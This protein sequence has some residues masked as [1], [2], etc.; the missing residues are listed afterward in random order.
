MHRWVFDLMAARLAGRP[1]YFPAQ[2]D[3]L[4]RCADTIPLERL[5]RF[6]RTL[7]ERRRTEQHPLA[8]RLV[9]ES[10]L[11]DYRRLFPAA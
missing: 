9:I 5:E 6:A 11:L 10:L 7:P 4:Q 8:A 3:A 2:R 1:R